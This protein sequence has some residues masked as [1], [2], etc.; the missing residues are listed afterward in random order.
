[1]FYVTD[2][3]LLT[4]EGLQI[5]GGD[6][7]GLGGL[8]GAYDVGG[9]IYARNA[10][11]ISNGNAIT[12]NAAD[13][14]GGLFVDYSDGVVLNSTSVSSN[15]AAAGSG[16][17][18]YVAESTDVTLHGNTIAGNECPGIC[19]GGG[20]HLG[21]STSVTLT[22]NLIQDN[23]GD[24]GGGLLLD[25]C[26]ATVSGN[27]II[28]NTAYQGGGVMVYFSD[29]V[30]GGNIITGNAATSGGGLYL[31]GN[32]PM[33][34]NNVVAGNHATAEGSGVYVERSSPHLLHTTIA[35]NTGGDGSGVHVT[36][37]EWD[38]EYK[39]SHVIMT[40]TIIASH[41][42]GLMVTE[43]NTATLNATLWYGN[44][45]NWESVGALAHAK[46]YS[47]DPAFAADGYHLTL[48]SAALDRGVEG[49]VTG[50]IDGD[51]RPQGAGYD[52]GADELLV[53]RV[54]LPLVVRSL[55]RRQ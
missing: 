26:D 46:D 19:W 37:L 35:R 13:I 27:R 20:V 2:D 21:G 7:D 8:Y 17:G 28:A 14:G 25:R 32:S 38:K 29:P 39:A 54:Y 42:V 52:I 4:I 22:N 15:T 47:D 40:N 49:E 50:D 9:A 12:S 23:A 16:G 48:G 5:T 24:Y 51:A 53:R 34:V 41:P 44:G 45:E 36:G 33:L 1:V 30:L 11:L 31:E 18:V 10:A 55:Q 3:V 43:A 6:A